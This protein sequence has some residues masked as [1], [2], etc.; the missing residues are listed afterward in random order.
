MARLYQESLV[1]VWLRLIVFWWLVLT[2]IAVGRDPGLLVNLQDFVS[3][4][5]FRLWHVGIGT[6]VAVGIVAFYLFLIKKK[7]V[8]D[9]TGRTERGLKTTIGAVP[10]PV[11]PIPRVMSKALRLPILDERIAM[12]LLSQNVPVSSIVPTASTVASWGGSA[13]Q[14]EKNKAFRDRLDEVVRSSPRMASLASGANTS[15]DRQPI[16]AHG[17]LFLAIWD[18]YSAHKQWPASHRRG[19]HGNRRLHEHC[20]AVASQC[21]HEISPE[22]SGWS[23]SG[24]YAKRRGGEPTLKFPNSSGYQPSLDDPLIPIVG[25]AHD[26]GK[27]IAYE[28][29][30][31]GNIKTNHE[32]GGNSLYD[33]DRGVI[34]DVLGPPILSQMPEFWAL[35]ARDRTAINVAVAHYHHPSQFPLNNFGQLYDPRAAALMMLVI[36][37]D[38]AVGAEESGMDTSAL[39]HAFTE[40]AKLALYESFVSILTTPGRI[41]GFGNGVDDSG[42]RVGQKH[43][44]FVAIKCSA[45]LSLIRQD[46]GL[47]L[48]SGDR[49]HEL[50]NRLLR[51]LHEK[52]LLYC[53][54]GG[55]DF[56]AYL[57]MYRVGLFHH[58][59]SKH[60]GDIAPALLIKIPGEEFQEFYSLTHLAV[61]P[62][63]AVVKG[64]IL[65][66]VKK[67]GL[68]QAQLKEQIKQAFERDA[69]HEN[70]YEEVEEDPEGKFLTKPQ[71]IEPVAPPTQEQKSEIQTSPEGKGRAGGDEAKGSAEVQKPAVQ[72]DEK[73]QKV[74]SAVNKLKKH[75]DIEALQKAVQRGRG[76]KEKVTVADLGGHQSENQAFNEDAFQEMM[77]ED[78]PPP[79]PPKK[80]RVR[81]EAP[82]EAAAVEVTAEQ[83]DLTSEVAASADAA[84]QEA[85]P[86][87]EQDGEPSATAQEVDSVPAS[88][89]AD[90]APSEEGETEDAVEATASTD[91]GGEVED[92]SIEPQIDAG[93]A[94]AAA[95][96]GLA[97]GDELPSLDGDE[98]DGFFDDEVPLGRALPDEPLQAVH[99][100]TAQPVKT[101]DSPP[102]ASAPRKTKHA[103]P[104]PVK[105][106]P[107]KVVVVRRGGQKL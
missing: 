24:V 80:K 100:K 39:T 84:E 36:T 75:G 66:H 63:N 47:S 12:W 57:P 64:V 99:A 38:K 6:V 22:G 68:D 95:S 46:L 74:L 71:E 76:G 83:P 79:P 18:T 105:R 1:A 28:V 96:H 16:T 30:R 98:E 4:M 29:D 70:V 26:L 104:K 85:D 19:G 72:V 97:E 59:T 13:E 11:E 82:A 5:Y 40:D 31:E 62:A 61:H 103:A 37:A 10:M 42:F 34:H 15:K 67:D 69:S 7:T 14:L 53:E 73:T 35:E 27:L 56:S 41:N 44:D 65:S 102:A 33:D 88:A 17:K 3:A 89:D 2:F 9:L 43:S 45:L 93:E 60:F 23:F 21:L 51:I 91:A 25:L 92:E 77:G 20:L 48:E 32:E 90:D 81:K 8:V 78:L 101:V 106:S 55:V 86:A 54:H 50:T 94:P 58:E 52:G 107:E 49:K 87:Q